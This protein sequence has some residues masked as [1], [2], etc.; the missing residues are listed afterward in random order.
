MCVRVC[1]MCGFV[2]QEV[3]WVEE[4]VQPNYP[5]LARFSCNY[6]LVAQEDRYSLAVVL[7]A[8]WSC[9]VFFSPC[10]FLNED[11]GS[12]GLCWDR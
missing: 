5:I 4:D 3:G 10:S 11:P 2:E 1:T 7:I 12:G 8:H 9:L 6:T